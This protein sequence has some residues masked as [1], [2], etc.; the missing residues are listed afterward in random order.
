M[1]GLSTHI[2]NVIAVSEAS[3]V[4][5]GGTKCFFFMKVSGMRAGG[6]AC[7]DNV[8]AR[9]G[10]HRGIHKSLRHIGKLIRTDTLVARPPHHSWRL[11]ALLRGA[12]PEFSV[13]RFPFDRTVRRGVPDV[14]RQLPF[15]RQ[16]RIGPDSSVGRAADF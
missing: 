13:S 3:L 12:A 15:G 11:A 16:R 6:R 14:R 4:S 8:T 5:F 2:D 10:P 1:G 7:R 9:S